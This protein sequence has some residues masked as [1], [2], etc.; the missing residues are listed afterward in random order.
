MQASLAALGE[1]GPYFAAIRAQFEGTYNKKAPKKVKFVQTAWCEVCKIM[2]NSSDAYATHLAGKKHNF[3]LEQLRNPSNNPMIGPEESAE[4]NKNK[5]VASVA[6]KASE[7]D[8]LAKRQKIVQAGTAA[9][10]IRTCTVCNV[11][12]N[13][14]AVFNSHLGG[15]KHKDMLQKFQASGS[16]GV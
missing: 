10:M 6:K 1:A 4:A 11:V 13:S 2:C 3:N 5:S 15:Q 9:A 8:M 14:L 16:G 12:C 7:E